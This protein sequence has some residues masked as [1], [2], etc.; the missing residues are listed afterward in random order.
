MPIRYPPNDRILSPPLR[1][2]GDQRRGSSLRVIWDYNSSPTDETTLS[3]V[4]L[5]R[6]IELAAESGGYN[7]KAIEVYGNSQNMGIEVYGNSQNRGMGF[8]SK[9]QTKLSGAGFVVRFLAKPLKKRKKTDHVERVY[10]DIFLNRLILKWGIEKEPPAAMLLISTDQ[11]LQRAIRA[12]VE[13]GFVIY[14]AYGEGADE[15]LIAAATASIH[16]RRL[17]QGHWFPGL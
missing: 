1:V 11:R 16:F 9:R 3:Y 7:V 10:C 2:F 8:S 17:Q 5:K 6:G 4:N 13:L 12:M 15:A 14:L